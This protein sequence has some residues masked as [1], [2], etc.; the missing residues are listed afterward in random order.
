MRLCALTSKPNIL[1][2]D[3]LAQSVITLIPLEA[4]LKPITGWSIWGSK[5][6]KEIGRVAR[7]IAKTLAAAYVR[8]RIIF[9]C[10]VTI[11]NIQRQ[12]Q[13]TSKDTS[14]SIISQLNWKVQVRGLHIPVK[15]A[16]IKLNRPVTLQDINYTSTQVKKQNK[17]FSNLRSV[18]TKIVCSKHENVRD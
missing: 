14:R 17:K 6:F 11:A 9:C 16:I 18:R 8:N 2:L 5:E 12:P 13:N 3:K 7:A 15:V 1:K 10:I 4:K